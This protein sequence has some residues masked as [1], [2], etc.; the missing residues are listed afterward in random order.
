MRVSNKYPTSTTECNWSKRG[1][2][3]YCWSTRLEFWKGHC[4]I[5]SLSSPRDP[6][7]PTMIVLVCLGQPF[8][9]PSNTSLFLPSWQIWISIL[10]LLPRNISGQGTEALLPSCR[11]HLVQSSYHWGPRTLGASDKNWPCQMGKYGYL[12]GPKSASAFHSSS[13]T[14]FDLNVYII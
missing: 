4:F 11:T 6:H 10:R 14:A 1:I 5:K 12:P 3:W 7:F 13:V 8:C 9:M 2:A